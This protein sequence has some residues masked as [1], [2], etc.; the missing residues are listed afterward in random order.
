MQETVGAKRS[1]AASE[2]VG[3]ERPSESQNCICSSQNRSGVASKVR[4]EGKWG[5]GLVFRIV[6]TRPGEEKKQGEKQTQTEADGI[7]IVSAKEGTENEE[8]DD[9][10]FS[11]FKKKRSFSSPP[12]EE[13]LPVASRETQ[14][15]IDV[16]T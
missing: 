7:Q 16:S 3:V 13:S 8:D 9:S 5:H 10:G 6:Y 1:E 11:L 12:K 15:S 4:E 2:K 14:C